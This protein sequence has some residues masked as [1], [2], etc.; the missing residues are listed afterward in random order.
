MAKI[1]T[2]KNGFTMVNGA[3][4]CSM[5]NV[6]EEES[7]K[8]VL[9]RERK[10]VERSEESMLLLL[11][12]LSRIEEGV[13]RSEVLALLSGPLPVSIRDT[14]ACGWLQTGELLGIVFT[15]IHRDALEQARLTVEHKVRESLLEKL[16]PPL[17][18]RIG[19]S[20]L[21]FPEKPGEKEDAEQRIR[22]NPFFYPEVFQKDMS[23]RI[24]DGAKRAMD[25]V[26][27]SLALLLFSP[28][29]VIMA[30]LVKTTSH[31]P[32]L[33]RQTRLGQFG[34]PFT[35]L[36][37]RS[38]HVNSDDSIH[39]EFIKGFI[40]NCMVREPDPETGEVVFKIRHDPRLTPIGSFLRKSSID[41]LPQF[42]NVLRG[43]MSLVGPRPPI[44]YEVA[45]YDVWHLNR[46]LARKPGITGLW[47]ISKRSL[48]TFDAM[49]RLDLQYI[50]TWS[51]WLDI[52][53]LLATPRAVLRGKGA[54]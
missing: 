29:L 46:I 44:P 25:L 2:T 22:F 4:A 49:V 9:Y 12:D 42:F 11:L 28:L 3:T 20:I 41:E 21:V 15:E 8:H 23:S 16:S 6:L 34:K 30:V 24:A 37:F 36:K 40:S 27:S 14:D 48:A 51:L 13:D 7:F 18:K 54:Y 1:F 53:I 43:E 35:F 10:R 31:G 33:Y 52:K 26:G 17:Y 19:L 50:R 45:E 5:E 38:M 39:R 32:V 47:Q